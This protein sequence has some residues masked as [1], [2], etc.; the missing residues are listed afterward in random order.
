MTGGPNRPGALRR[1]RTDRETVEQMHAIA[2]AA[3]QR[4]DELAGEASLAA[5]C[6]DTAGADL[7]A[8]AAA[9]QRELHH[10]AQSD[11]ADYARTRLAHRVL[12]LAPDPHA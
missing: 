1:L 4:A 11:A 12:V 6:G 2:K 5:I 7:L 10:A 8:A 3:R 9:E